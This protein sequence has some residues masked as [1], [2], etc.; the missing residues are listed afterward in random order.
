M[1]TSIYWASFELLFPSF[2]SLLKL[3]KSKNL[4]KLLHSKIFLR[5]VVAK[6][7]PFKDSFCR[8]KDHLDDS[9]SSTETSHVTL[10]TR[11]NVE[12]GVPGTWPSLPLPPF[13]VKCYITQL[14]KGSI[15]VPLIIVGIDFESTSS[16]IGA[17]YTLSSI[18]KKFK[19]TATNAL[20]SKGVGV[21][22]HVEQTDGVA[23][24]LGE[25][26][27]VNHQISSSVVPEEGVQHQTIR[28]LTQ[29]MER[30]RHGWIGST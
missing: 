16:I 26:T 29:R 20:K 27:N 30:R 4:G 7:I 14:L 3:S 2:S 28:F 13:S 9:A 8:S 25:N 21:N 17:K 11:E 24:A 6:L 1:E 15:I 18:N 22:T 12:L 19:G 10:P 23:A 5:T